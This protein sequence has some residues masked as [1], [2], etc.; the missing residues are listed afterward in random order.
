MNSLTY[1]E[2]SLPK[3]SNKWQSEDDEGNQKQNARHPL[4]Q[5]V[6]KQ[7]Q[8]PIPSPTNFRAIRISELCLPMNNP[9]P[10]P[11]T[12]HNHPQTNS[13]KKTSLTNPFKTISQ[14]QYRGDIIMDSCKEVFIALVKNDHAFFSKQCLEVHCDGAQV[15]SKHQ[16]VGHYRDAYQGFKNFLK[17]LEKGNLIENYSVQTAFCSKGCMAFTGPYSHLKECT[18]CQIPKDP[19]CC[20][21][22]FKPELRIRELFK[23]R[24]FAKIMRFLPA[25]SQDSKIRDVFDGQLFKSLFKHQIKIKNSQ[26]GRYE[27]K[28]GAPH[29]FEKSKDSLQLV[30]SC[31]SSVCTSSH[32]TF[33]LYSAVIHN[34]PVGTRLN[35]FFVIPLMSVP[36]SSKQTSESFLQPMMDDF[37]RWA[38]DGVQVYDGYT[39]TE[40]Q[41]RCIVPFFC[42]NP[43]SG[44]APQVMPCN[45]C[46]V[47]CGPE[48][49]TTTSRDFG[50]GKDKKWLKN[51]KEQEIG[52]ISPIHN[53]FS[54]ILPYC[55]P[56]DDIF[57]F[58]NIFKKMFSLFLDPSYGSSSTL[59]D[60]SNKRI[61]EKI[62]LRAQFQLPLES[63]MKGNLKDMNIAMFRDLLDLFPILFME[64]EN[65]T[66]ICTTFLLLSIVCKALMGEEIEQKY[67]S[68]YHKM[69]CA[70]LALFEKYVL[71][72][73]PAPKTVA[74]IHFHM[75]YHLVD[76]IEQSG[77]IR[78]FGLAHQTPNENSNFQQDIAY[79]LL[80]KFPQENTPMGSVYFSHPF[81][82]STRGSSVSQGILK[83]VVKFIIHTDRGTKVQDIEAGAV[84]R[85]FSV[86]EFG[87]GREPITAGSVLCLP[88][89][90]AS[91]LTFLHSEAFVECTYN[92][93]T[94]YLAVG[95]RVI[96]TKLEPISLAT[97]AFK[98]PRE[99]KKRNACEV[100]KEQEHIACLGNEYDQVTA[101]F[102]YYGSEL[103]VD[104]KL[105]AY[106]LKRITHQVVP[107]K[108][109][110][111]GSQG[112]RTYLMDSNVAFT[113]GNSKYSNETVVTVFLK[114][115]E[116][117]ANIGKIKRR[118]D[119]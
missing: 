95:R 115:E 50:L 71:P 105:V 73:H 7:C 47:Q 76:I 17:N 19:N 103:P 51:A 104:K 4:P 106:S 112:I 38:Q 33:V 62:I 113:L 21:Y 31:H 116:Y 23:D 60:D 117:N 44:F 87:S 27:S 68:V 15:I 119:A 3:D 88:R 11:P 16:D 41:V 79:H 108:G 42:G 92:D 107:I 67:L 100:T 83:A 114:E 80:S 102:Y 32:G 40:I 93:T 20:Y 56:I 85:N 13:T 49:L 72:G 1:C 48:G 65:M 5:K 36:H 18:L 24:V 29:Y 70:G 111:H 74:D 110:R 59:L 61:L 75:L 96:S 78:S 98:F 57:F 54:T 84:T 9:S 118:N 82:T 22:Y 66:E 52:F 91:P 101:G 97:S 35:P 2:S 53:L 81:E 37:K 43:L 89:V 90:A 12:Y 26:T 45:F 28:E 10:E 8:E 58:E 69:I 77:P 6:L 99:L 63:F 30:L 94:Y 64:F 86:L 39:K 14:T 109:V 46:K 25:Y 55:L 34:L